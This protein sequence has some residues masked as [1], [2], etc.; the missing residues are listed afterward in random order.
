MAFACD[1]SQP[2]ASTIRRT[3]LRKPTAEA[4]VGRIYA[5]LLMSTGATVVRRSWLFLG[6]IFAFSEKHLFSVWS[7]LLRLAPNIPLA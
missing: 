2:F 1:G 4:L 3:E 7:F 6:R 5:E